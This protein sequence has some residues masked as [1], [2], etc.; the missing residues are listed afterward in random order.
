M[1]LKTV[2][3]LL[4]D[5]IN[6]PQDPSNAIDS[7]LNAYWLNRDDKLAMRNVIW[8]EIRHLAFELENYEPNPE[9]RKYGFLSAEQAIGKTK[10]T[11]SLINAKP[12]ADTSRQ[13]RRRV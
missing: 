1:E 3:R 7:F 8:Q 6:A 4:E 11:I 9:I 13:N 5:I 10:R 12:V 2:L